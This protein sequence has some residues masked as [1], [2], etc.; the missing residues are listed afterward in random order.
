MWRDYCPAPLV[1]TNF[2]AFHFI[3]QFPNAVVQMLNLMH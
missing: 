2:C 1:K 3:P